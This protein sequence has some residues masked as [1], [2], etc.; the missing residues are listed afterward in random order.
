MLSP[1]D[2]RIYR[3]NRRTITRSLFLAVAAD[4]INYFAAAARLRSLAIYMRARA[5][6]ADKSTNCLKLYELVATL[7]TFSPDLSASIIRLRIRS[8]HVV[9]VLLGRNFV[10]L[11]CKSVLK[12]WFLG[13]VSRKLENLRWKRFIWSYRFLM[14][15]SGREKMELVKNGILGL[16]YYI[17]AQQ[18]YKISFVL[19]KIVISGEL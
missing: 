12:S 8:S 18:W 5:E 3:E 10:L 2:E 9:R 4:A 19:I 17:I 15:V 16:K 14:K 6:A 13:V 7:A 1:V 11:P